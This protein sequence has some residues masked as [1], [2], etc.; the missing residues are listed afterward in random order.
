MGGMNAQHF[1]KA[2]PR[3]YAQPFSDFGK[4]E[5]EDGVWNK[6]NQTTNGSAG[7]SALIFPS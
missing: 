3:T 5:P 4:R 1:K 6:Q 7:S 2:R